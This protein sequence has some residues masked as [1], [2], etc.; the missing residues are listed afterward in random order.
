MFVLWQKLSTQVLWKV[1]GVVF[2]TY[3]FSNHSNNKFKLL[4]LKGIYLYG[5]MDDWEKFNKISLLEKK[6]FYIHLIM[7]YINESD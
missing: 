5:Y 4:L 2:N 7:E 1:K 6:D 3:K